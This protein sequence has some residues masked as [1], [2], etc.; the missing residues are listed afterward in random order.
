MRQSEK[1]LCQ[2]LLA[3][4]DCS[5][6]VF[7][8]KLVPN[9][10]PAAIIGV[11]MPQLRKLARSIAGSAQAS[12]FLT[13]L[14]HTYLEENNLH[15]L[16]LEPAADF[17]SALQLVNA[18]LPYVDNWA[19][20]DLLAPKAFGRDLTALYQ[21]I[22]IWLE[23]DRTYTIRF[24]VGMLM[25]YY[26]GDAFHQEVLDLVIRIQSDAYYVNMMRAWFFATALARQYDATLPVIQDQ[27]LDL[28][29]HN[30]TIQKAI[31]SRR[32]DDQ[33]KTYLRMLKA[34]RS[35]T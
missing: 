32:I 20:C 30:K 26:L 10:D 13:D 4:Q 33:T 35:N 27:R 2:Q 31:E 23:S 8:R 19:T 28:W 11:R 1:D 24:A 18:F 25:R 7:I 3:Y 17:A 9:L 22:T 34:T 5:Y 21:Q 29:T 14:P 12:R 15:A 16:L 6:Q